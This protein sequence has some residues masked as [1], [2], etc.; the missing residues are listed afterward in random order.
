MTC[1]FVS[2]HFNLTV[3]ESILLISSRYELSHGENDLHPGW[4]CSLD[5][6]RARR[7]NFHHEET[8]VGAPAT[9]T[10]FQTLIN[11][12]TQQYGFNVGGAEG[13]LQLTLG[14]DDNIL[15]ISKFGPSILAVGHYFWQDGK[16]VRDPETVWCIN[17]PLWIP[18]QITQA[19]GGTRQ[20]AWLTPD[21]S[22]V[23]T[24][25]SRGQAELAAFA[26]I[27]ARTL[28]DQGWLQDAV[29]YIPESFT[30]DNAGNS[31]TIIEMLDPTG[32]LFAAAQAAYGVHD[33][34][35][36]NSI[37]CPL[38]YDG[39]L[40]TCIWVGPASRPDMPKAHEAICRELVPLSS[41]VGQ[42]PPWRGLP[43]ES[44]YDGRI[45]RLAEQEYVISSSTMIITCASA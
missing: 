42:I 7:V 23:A 14:G 18:F 6:P 44:G 26:T 28:R 34:I 8:F 41:Y 15:A 33:I 1:G 36:C 19:M 11:R 13:S 25:Y 29:R 17:Y 12:L 27:W 9:S 20:Y 22:Q 10:T 43:N 45:I 35:G 39:R 37:R 16:T 2:G 5:R 4:K 30:S 21:R 40:F 32:N 38:T 31:P 24:F 3:E